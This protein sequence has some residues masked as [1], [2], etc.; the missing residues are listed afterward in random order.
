MNM[1]FFLDSFIFFHCINLFSNFAI[2]N[3]IVNYIEIYNE[4]VINHTF[5]VAFLDFL[6]Q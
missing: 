4:K 1:E 3:R 2:I 5:D 6:Q